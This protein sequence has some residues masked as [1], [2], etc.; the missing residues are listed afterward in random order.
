M[1]I[2]LLLLRKKCRIEDRIVKQ[3]QNDL[4]ERGVKLPE[5][6]FIKR[7]VS[8]YLD[9]YFSQNIKR[10]LI[11]SGVVGCG[12]TT[13]VQDFLTRRN[14]D[15]HTIILTCDDTK[16]R[17]EVAADSKFIYNMIRNQTSKP[18]FLFIDEV[19]KSEDVFDAIKFAYDHL[20]LNFIVSGSNPDYLNTVAKKRLQRRAEFLMMMPFSL[21]EILCFENHLSE[22][23]TTVF[24][25]IF[26]DLKLPDEIPTISLTHSIEES[27]KKY[28]DFG[29]TPRAYLVEDVQQKMIEVK[30]VVERGF[31]ALSFGNSSYLDQITVDLANLHSKEF[32]YQ[33]IFQKTGLRR[34]ENIN[35][36]IDQLLNHGYLL[37]KKPKILVD[38]RST[39]ISSYS[40]IDPGFVTYLTGEFSDEVNQGYR[41]E[42]LVFSSLRYFQ[43]MLSFKSEISYYKP[44]TIDS[45]SKLKFLQGE[46]D[47]IFTLGR[48]QIPIEVKA[49][50]KSSSFNL[51]LMKNFMQL[52]KA[53]FGIVLYQGAPFFAKKESILFWPYWAI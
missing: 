10:G 42:G 14:R 24:K 46:I 25:R 19:Q 39:Y 7:D 29:G 44:Y 13:V 23:V 17:A 12:K 50:S 20:S 15:E 53:P 45:S 52:T 3:S 36:K 37:K 34:R 21:S 28:F 38:D 4:S 51:N 2:R 43:Q 27:C 40:F 5:S 31:E 30:Q 47:F 48:K 41:A 8:K 6:R 33:G 32:T 22:D 11:L 9:F 26:L 1:K 35:H 49:G 16:L 18:V